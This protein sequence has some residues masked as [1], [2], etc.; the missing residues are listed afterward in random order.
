MNDKEG[1]FNLYSKSPVCQLLVSILVIFGIGLTLFIILSVVGRLVFSSDFSV[2]G[3]HLTGFKDSDISFLRYFLIIQD[4]SLLIIPSI[5]MLGLLNSG[6]LIGLAE[7]K[8]VPVK[9]VVLVIIL[10]FCIFPVTSFTGQINSSMHFP[11]WLSG[12][13]RWM[14]EKEDEANGMID[15]IMTSHTIGIMIL[16]ILLI[17]ALP[18]IA[19]ELIFRGVFQKIFCNLFKS[20]HMAIWFTAFLFS[21][22]HFQFFG[23]IPRFILGLVFGYLFF[24]SGTLWLPVISH[25][26]NNA[27][28]VIL[29][30]V[31]GMEKLNAIT[32]TPLLKQVIGLPLPI[33]ISMGI[34]YYFWNK[35]KTVRELR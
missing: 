27:F 14:A 21:T 12:V 18:A 35:N 15:L 28:P 5:I 32:N 10:T 16:N 19:E 8:I 20:A 25:F 13:E 11:D 4:I 9:E 22:L 34:L 3:K 29:V 24:W 23:F 26:V 1:R 30:Y 33:I 7:F 17:A 31:V 6:R 2:L